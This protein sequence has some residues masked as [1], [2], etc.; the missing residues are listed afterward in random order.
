[1]GRKLRTHVHVTNPDTGERVVLG[2]DSDVPDW[3]VDAI[4]NKDAWEADSEEESSKPAKRSAVTR[5]TSR[6]GDSG[7]D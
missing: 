6:G 1:M 7:S 3:A 2:P 5:R 4:S